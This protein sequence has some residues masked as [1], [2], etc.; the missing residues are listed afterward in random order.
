MLILMLNASTVEI[1]YKALIA[2][3][4]PFNMTKVKLLSDQYFFLNYFPAYCAFYPPFLNESN[5]KL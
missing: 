2:A 3:K 5:Q 4:I 1:F